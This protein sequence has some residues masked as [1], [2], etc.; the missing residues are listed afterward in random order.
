VPG[1]DDAFHDEFSDLGQAV[2]LLLEDGGE[3][4]LDVE[5]AQEPSPDDQQ[6]A[7]EVGAGHCL[8]P[9]TDVF[10]RDEVGLDRRLEQRLFTGEIVVEGSPARL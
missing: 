2:A 3:V 8:E 7:S 1:F 4:A 9:L 10:Y 5:L 6:L